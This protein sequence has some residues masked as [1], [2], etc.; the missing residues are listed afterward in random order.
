MWSYYFWDS[1]ENRT[2]LTRQPSPEK[3]RKN[4]NPFCKT[5]SPYTSTIL[6]CSFFGGTVGSVVGSAVAP[7]PAGCCA[8]AAA[9]SV[10]GLT[11]GTCCCVKCCND[12]PEEKMSDVYGLR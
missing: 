11:F 9:G 8:G 6:F 10:I 5:V 2:P 1:S 12:P 7:S 4:K 3:P